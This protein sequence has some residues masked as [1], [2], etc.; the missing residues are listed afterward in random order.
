MISTITKDEYLKIYSLT[1]AALEVHNNLGRGL[2][3]P[4]YQEA[5][6]Y[7]LIDRKISFEREKVLKTYYKN[8]A[9]NKIYI[10]DFYSEGI[11]L[12][13]K[14]VSELCSEH[15]AQLM[16]YMRITKSTIGLLINFGERKLRTERYIYQKDTDDFVLLSEKNFST[17]VID[18]I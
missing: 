8:R 18:N 4:I 16:N 2:D 13:L 17:Y 9:L 7:E 6:Q 15:R 3:E 14:S 12:E 1:G 11:I 10:A 5:L